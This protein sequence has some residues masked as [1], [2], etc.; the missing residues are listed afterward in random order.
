MCDNINVYT[1]AAFLIFNTEEPLNKLSDLR[2]KIYVSTAN[3]TL[4]TLHM[5]SVIEGFPHP[6]GRRKNFLLHW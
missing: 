4:A 6:C 5:W 3:C 2:E 1:V